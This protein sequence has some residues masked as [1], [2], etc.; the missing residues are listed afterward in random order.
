MPLLHSIQIRYVDYDH[1][2]GKV[3]HMYNPKGKP[4]IH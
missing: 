3:Y 1:H 2:F 4:K